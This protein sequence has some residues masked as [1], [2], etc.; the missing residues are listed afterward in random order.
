MP[1]DTTL[2]DTLFKEQKELVGFLQGQGQVSFSQS[3]E[4]FLSKT[5]L[6]SIASYFE[7]RI[8]NTIT[9]YAARVSNADEALTSLVRIKAI[10]RQY[11]TYFQWREGNRSVMPFFAMFGTVLKDSAKLEL[12]GEDLAQAAAA[13]LELGDLRNLLV[14]ENF[15]SYPLEMTSDEV[16]GLYVAALKFVTYIEVKL[17]PMPVV[18][19][20]SE[21]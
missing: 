12:K 16:Y 9:D 6:L 10:E 7:S 21:A 18:A 20:P 4:A 3:V 5:L 11:F 2:I 8:T 14:H 15:A 19:S 13:F 1:L 17:N